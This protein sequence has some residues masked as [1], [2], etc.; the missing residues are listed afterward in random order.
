MGFNYGSIALKPAKN[1]MVSARDHPDVVT[2]YLHEECK[3]GRVI[4]PVGSEATKWVAQ[5]SRFGVIPKGHTPGKWRLIVDLSA[6]AGHSVNDGIDTQLCFL[7]YTS[8]DRAAAVI[9]ELGHQCMLSKIDIQ[10]A[11][12]IVPV[13]PE[14]SLLLGMKWQGQLY[15]DT[16]LP[17]GLRSTPKIFNT[18]ADGLAW[19]LQSVG[20]Q[21]VLHYLDDFLLLGPPGSAECAQAL[22]TTLRICDKLGVPIAAEKVEGPT[23]CL[24]FLGIE[25]DTSAWQ[26]RLPLEKLH[27][28]QVLEGLMEE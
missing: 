27:R 24:P 5:I 3:K 16:T 15:V 13:H 17:F 2:K 28:I 1:N 25:M 9:R 4:G 18:A 7:E 19:V 23:R 22:V 12:R 8:V 10:S 26:L 6:P 14:D 21:F 11:Y 20:V